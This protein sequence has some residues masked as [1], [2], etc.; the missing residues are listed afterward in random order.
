LTALATPDAQ[1]AIPREKVEIVRGIIDSLNAM[2]IDEALRCVA[3]GFEMDRSSSIG[4]LKGVYRGRGGAGTLWSLLL[5]L[6]TTVRWD[7]VEAIDIDE[8]RV[9]VVNRVQMRG[10]GRYVDE[11]EAQLLTVRDGKVERIKSYRSRSEALEAAGL[12]E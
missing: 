6:W 9:I 12:R 4:P 2:R 8:S 5:H 1:Q 3:E 7:L 10:R 11:V